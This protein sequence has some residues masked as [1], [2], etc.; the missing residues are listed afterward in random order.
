MF[1][2]LRRS[3]RQNGVF[4]SEKG[5]DLATQGLAPFL[6]H[7]AAG[8]AIASSPDLKAKVCRKAGYE[9]YAVLGI[10][11]PKVRYLR[12]VPRKPADVVRD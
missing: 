3:F 1:H 5:Q 7:W 9:P 6:P 4:P 10:G 2:I 11:H 8:G 12:P